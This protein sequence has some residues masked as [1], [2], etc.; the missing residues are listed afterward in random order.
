LDRAVREIGYAVSGT[1]GTFREAR[2]ALGKRNFD[3]VLLDLGIDEQ[4]SPEIADLLLERKIPFAFL[5]GDKK[6]FEARHAKVPLLN[7]PYTRAELRP[8]LETLIG[9]P[10]GIAI[11]IANAG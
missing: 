9:S 7:K 3:A 4:Q 2:K 11:K 1:A 5:I 6:S 10:S 8:L